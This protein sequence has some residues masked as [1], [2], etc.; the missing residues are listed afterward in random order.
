[1]R[2]LFVRSVSSS[3]FFNAVLPAQTVIHICSGH[4]RVG[5][6]FLLSDLQAVPQQPS[7]FELLLWA[8][9]LVSS[10]FY[11]ICCSVFSI[12]PTKNNEKM[13][14]LFS[15]VALELFFKLENYSRKFD[16][17]RVS[18]SVFYFRNTKTKKD[19][20]ERNHTPS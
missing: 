16:S 11:L 15:D 12:L 5:Q 20:W 17:K 9:G 1:M 3:S 4:I 2:G 14:L 19:F 10:F 18:G 6:T 13:N 8:F 7:A